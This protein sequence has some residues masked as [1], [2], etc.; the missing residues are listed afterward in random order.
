MDIT[1]PTLIS[2]PHPILGDGREVAYAEFENRETL[3][4]YVK[5]LGIKVPYGRVAVWHNGHR[6][7]DAL[8]ERLIPRRGDQVIIRARVHGGG[9]GGKV[10]KMV[11]TI[12]VI[13]VAAAAAVATGGAVLAAYGVTA[14]TA[15]V[16]TLAVA[17]IAGAV[18]SSLV[19]IAGTMLVNSLL[20]TPSPAANSA[21]L[22]YAS[23]GAT[24]SSGLSLGSSM[25]A[26]PSSM[27]AAKYGSTP[28][29]AVNPTYAISGGKNSARPWEPMAL[30]FGRHKVVPDLAAA[31]FTEYV[32]SD[33]YLNQA[34]HFGI[35]GESI[36][37][38]DVK[39]GDTLLTNYEGVQTQRSKAD[40][41]LDLFPGNVDTIQGFN[42]LNSD[43]WVERTTSLNTKHIKVEL[44]A[45][46]YYFEDDGSLSVRSVSFT[47]QYRATGTA[48]W[49]EVGNEANT[50]LYATHYWSLQR[51]NNATD[52]ENRGQVEYG[53]TAF[54]DHVSNEVVVYDNY[55]YPTSTGFNPDGTYY[56]ANEVC[57]DRYGRW[58]W[59]PHPHTLGKPWQG[60]A[61]DP[62]K[63]GMVVDQS[64]IV[65]SG[66]SQN[67]TRRTVEWDTPV[68]QYDIRVI[69]NTGDIKSTRET[70]ESAVNQILCFQPDNADYADQARYAVRIRASAQLQ[71]QIE[72]LN[73]IASATCP[74]WNG[75]AW[76]IQETSNPAWWF[77]WYAR[78]KRKASG[79]R[80]Y[81]GGLTDAQLDVDSIK[82]WALFC[83]EKSLTFNYVLTQRASAHD[84]LTT[85]ARAGRASY[86]WQTGKLGVIWDS[87]NNPVSAMIG[88]FNIL[89]GT[90]EVAYINEATAD[91]IVLN[92][93][94]PARG[95]EMDTVRVDVPN[96]AR[97]NNS[98]TLDLDGCTDVDMA[99]REANLIAASQ[100]FHRRRVTWEM[101][102]EG[103]VATRGDVVQLSHDLTVWGYSGRL[104]G[105]TRETLT[106]DRTVPSSGTGWLS[107]RA[108]DGEMYT[109]QVSGASGEV[110]T[111]NIITT[112]PEDFPVP[113]ENPDIPVVDWAWQ[114]DPL[115]TPGRRIKII[116]VQPAGQ[117]VIRFSGV[118]DSADYYASEYNLYGYTPPRDGLL[119]G[120]VIFNLNF[121]ERILVVSEDLIAVTAAW[122]VS[123]NAS[124]AVNVTINDVPIPAIET[125]DREY[126]FNARTYDNISV[127][128]TP[129]VSKQGTPFT[130]TYRVV[131][132]T[133]EP[134]TV[135][136]LTSVLRDGLTVLSWDQA[137]DLRALQY[138]LRIGSNWTN[139]RTVLITPT[140]QSYA[141][142]NG[143]YHVAAR[144]ATPWGLVVYG[145]PD[146]LTIYGA[147]IVRNYIQTT[148]E[149]PGWSGTVT[150][151]CTVVNDQLTLA[152]SG[153]ILGAP[154]IF[155]PDDILWY[156]GA[157]ASGTYQTNSANIVNIGYPT[158]VKIDFSL[159]EYPFNFREN[160]LAAEDIF[161]DSDILGDSDRQFYSVKPQIRFAGADA[162]WGGWVN[163]TPGLVN[164][165]YFDVRL[166][167]ETTDPMIVP[168]VESFEWSVDVPDLIQR[169]EAVTIPSIGQTVAYLK[170]FHAVPNLQI[171]ILNAQ[172]GD[173]FVLTNS[174]DS[175]FTI[176][177]YNGVTAVSRQIN[178]IAQGY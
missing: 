78:G 107:L 165:Q 19:M 87:A 77:L 94:N 110:D 91:E 20:P 142:A 116:D 140:T 27:S 50:S 67:P 96:V 149:E 131:G 172:N 123:S 13:A 70:N 35:Q 81:G 37:L 141:V 138:E 117:D 168:F 100:A 145:E 59:T 64:D 151:Y 25:A 53:S 143:T 109:V 111:L 122:T 150:G 112:L 132:L 62:L 4:T 152:P 156:G 170:S 60:I 166:L 160:T 41:K 79:D 7:P 33:Q 22:S 55:C 42:L 129:R 103:M 108:P 88:P 72:D 47:V 113:S 178:W 167:V 164:A 45:Q 176:N 34:F 146:T 36:N 98:V 136:G 73:A 8:W 17:A 46:L 66:A 24:G 15:T 171:T 3:G 93:V 75:T 69:K 26:S 5:R 18:A 58:V 31:T 1:R 157:G 153:D 114:F 127:T 154:D 115:A 23:S 104:I 28:A 148:V 159:S 102:I 6:V 130:R 2:H 163:Y 56:E 133:I 128:V 161:A 101:D 162:I 125:I 86:T 40:G 174:Q 57:E 52:T 155:A 71:G 90:F 21:N 32:G 44:A 74:V 29:Y 173:R 65:L 175:N 63:A 120:G 124:V 51:M 95:W 84:V 147:S 80:V 43:G 97:T 30:I 11:A 121:S 144:V 134:P 39:I 48:T 119:L 135:T 105:G 12:A 38:T 82:A 54:A 137:R 89:S 10:L 139:A 68:G 14:A 106:L 76:V 83:E 118:D 61:P 99:G 9:G 169:A 49:V 92:F 158:P 177:I 16:G 126:T 85:I